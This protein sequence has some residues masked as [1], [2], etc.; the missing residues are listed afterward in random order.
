MDLYAENILDHFRNPRC[1]GALDDST[2]EHRATNPSCGDDLTLTLKIE[3]DMIKEVGW[4]GQGCAISQAAIS[5]LSEK[6]TNMPLK[7]AEKIS[8]KDIN[9]LLNVPIGPRRTKC[10]LLC[11]HALK[12]AL[13]SLNDEPAQSW[14]ETI[15]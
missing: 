15:G 4:I 3:S 5:L 13:H 1:R 7:K 12:N 9:N 2:V 8:A 10:A 14:A 11:L 6:L